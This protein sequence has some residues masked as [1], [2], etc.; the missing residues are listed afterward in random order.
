MFA[1]HYSAC[2]LAS[3]I[4]KRM[5]LKT[6][7]FSVILIE[8]PHDKTN[9]H[10]VVHPAKTQISLGIRPVWSE[11]S[12]SAWRKLWSLATHWAHNEGSD[13]TGQMPR[14]IWVLA[15]RTLTL[16]VLSIG[17]SYEKFS[18]MH[19]QFATRDGISWCS[20]SMAEEWRL[21]MYT[22][23]WMQFSV[24]F[25]FL[26]INVLHGYKKSAITITI[27]VVYRLMD[28]LTR[29]WPIIKFEP[30]HKKT[31]LQGLRPGKT[32]TGLLSYRD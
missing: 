12:L 20:L 30:C 31:C 26:F 11:S 3:S 13:Q 16:L 4:L 27:N 32:L 14:L 24:I 10:V 8:P 18:P 22:N 28:M 23:A 19:I 17:G 21:H 1:Y 6:L 7:S 25:Y 2:K 29:Q 5:K 9:N 15:G